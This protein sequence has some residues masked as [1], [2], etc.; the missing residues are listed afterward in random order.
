MIKLFGLLFVVSWANI[1]LLE[2]KNGYDVESAGAKEWQLKDVSALSVVS[3]LLPDCSTPITVSTRKSG[4]KNWALTA[5]LCDHSDPADY[6]IKWITQ[7][8]TDV[9]FEYDGEGKSWKILAVHC[10]N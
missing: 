7:E 3:Y 9:Y 5:T 6:E 10:G 4:A 2:N 8:L 1:A